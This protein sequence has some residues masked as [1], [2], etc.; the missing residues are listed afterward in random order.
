[1]TEE[2]VKNNCDQYDPEPDNMN[3]TNCSSQDVIT[4]CDN[5]LGYVDEAFGSSSSVAQEIDLCEFAEEVADLFWAFTESEEEDSFSDVDDDHTILS[6]SFGAAE[7]PNQSGS[8]LSQRYIDH[9][10][11]ESRSD[12]PLSDHGMSVL[13]KREKSDLIIEP[14]RVRAP[15]QE[16]KSEYTPRSGTRTHLGENKISPGRNIA[17]QG[18]PSNTPKSE[19]KA[20]KAVWK[21]VTPKLEMTKNIHPMT[22]ASA[23]LSESPFVASPLKQL[24]ISDFLLR[25]G[26]ENRPP[27]TTLSETFLS[28]RHSTT[29]QIGIKN[30]SRSEQVKANGCTAD[31][32]KTEDIDSGRGITTWDSDIDFKS[33]R[34][35]I[36]ERAH[37]ENSVTK[38]QRR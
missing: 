33:I 20:V 38:K 25:C 32:A 28:E 17:S 6:P 31:A 27:H 5:T 7:D 29:S 12:A 26:K 22:H 18:H 16:V 19:L 3:L 1:M 23:V 30:H 24:L 14:K 36:Q 37:H 9:G 21:R 2:T 10:E 4:A 13:F 34:V 11:T 8:S 35:A 15:D